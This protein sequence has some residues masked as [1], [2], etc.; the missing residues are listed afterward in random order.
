MLSWW[1]NIQVAIAME[2]AEAAGSPSIEIYPISKASNVKPS[3]LSALLW[4][5][6]QGQVF[7]K[8]VLLGVLLGASVLVAT[9]AIQVYQGVRH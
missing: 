5:R 6:F 7:F 1:K 4:C 8:S 3:V 9:Q 2:G